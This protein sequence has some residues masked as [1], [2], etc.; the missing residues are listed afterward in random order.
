MTQSPVIIARMPAKASRDAG[1]RRGS[2]A[3]WHGPQVYSPAQEAGERQLMQRRTADLAANDWAAHSAIDAISFN[4]VGT[5]LKPH[6]TIPAKILGIE[7]EEAAAIGEQMEWLFAQWMLEADARGMLHFF[8]LQNLGLRTLLA[9]GE[10]LHL[11]VMFSE[12]DREKYGKTFSF[13]LQTLSPSRLL[14]PLDK[15]AD[16][17][18]KDGIA[19]TPF[20]R[21]ESYYIATPSVNLGGSAFL[22]ALTSNDFTCVKAFTG[23]RKGIFHLFKYEQDEQ[24]R[25]ISVFAPGISLFHNLSDTI[26]YELY[27]Q[28]IA[29]SFPVFI[30]QEKGMELPSFVEE[31]TTAYS[32]EKKYYQ[33][34][35]EGQILYGEA[36]EKPHVL[37][38]SRPSNNFSAFTEIVTRAM[39][40]TVGIPYESLTKDFSKTNYSSARA[41][42]NEAWKLYSWYR[43]FFAGHYCQHVWEMVL[44]EA[45]LRGM[46]TLPK[47]AKGFYEARRF[48]CNADWIGPAK[49]FV[50]P[51]KEIEATVLALKNNLMTYADA[52]AER[53][54]DL[55]EGLEQMAEERKQ[56]GLLPPNILADTPKVRLQQ[57]EDENA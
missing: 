42:L 13:C 10:L 7:K 2:L 28:L 15:M 49:G 24:I 38:S 19:F 20:G 17:S 36:G 22:N 12:A 11:P 26:N 41:A 23:H 8:D 6:S 40:S 1:A 46:F 5:G 18:I 16:T 3:D 4:S 34:I 35:E 27:A 48:W 21:P 50:D 53:G 47:K 32:E 37:E 55:D 31:E 44:E 29:A 33:R 56:M 45:F 30:E 39:A 14:T 54:G 52:W 25:G 57:R 9:Q 43:N 51:V